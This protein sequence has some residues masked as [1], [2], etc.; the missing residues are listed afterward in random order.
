MLLRDTY[1]DALEARI[2]PLRQSI[3]LEVPIIRSPDKQVTEEDIPCAIMVEDE[4]V[5]IKYSN[6]DPL[7]YPCERKLNVIF[8]FW[9]KSDT[10]DVRNIL[11]QARQLIFA[12]K[13]Q[14]AQGVFIKEASILGPFNQGIPKTHGMQLNTFFIYKDNGPF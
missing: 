10:G 4:D 13:G 7:G 3:P 14:L 2:R 8:Q 12:N 5:I 1:I 11:I 6:R 9:D